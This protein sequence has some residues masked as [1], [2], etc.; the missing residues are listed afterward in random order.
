MNW[1]EQCAVV[2]PCFNE[3][4][5]IHELVSTVRCLVP[6]VFVIDDGSTD[7]TAV[8]AKQA[9]AA[10]ILQSAQRGKGAALMLGFAAARKDGFAYALC[11]DGDAQ[12]SPADI[13]AFFERCEASGADLVIGN[14]FP[15]ARAMPWLRRGVNLFMTR[16][17]SWVAGERLLDTQCGFRLVKLSLL[18]AIQTRTTHFEFESEL[19]IEV[20]R[21]G[22]RVE[23]V[24]IRTIYRSERSKIRPL[25]DSIRW[26]RWLAR[27]IT[28]R[29]GK[30]LRR[31]RLLIPARQQL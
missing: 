13:P 2:I 30:R 25:R 28:H 7:A 17:L 11:M 4:L 10:V 21:C 6:T 24:P 9:G 3:S 15:A 31:A 1:R 22:G 26:L 18:S 19:L 16:M 14:R 8:L 12:H 20:I 27:C 5:T 29:E 23:F